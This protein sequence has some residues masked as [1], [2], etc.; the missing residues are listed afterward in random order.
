MHFTA[1]SQRCTTLCVWRRTRLK[2]CLSCE[3]LSAACT[4]YSISQAQMYYKSN[5]LR[6]AYTNNWNNWWV[7][8]LYWLTT[9]TVRTF[10]SMW[11]WSITILC[12]SS[13]T[14]FSFFSISSASPQVAILVRVA[15]LMAQKTCSDWHTCLFRVWC[16]QI[17]HVGVSGPKNRQIMTRK[18]LDL[19]NF[20]QNIALTLEPPRVN[21]PWTSK[22]VAIC[23][24]FD[25]SLPN[26]V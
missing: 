17:Y 16:L 25:Q 8:K 23:L 11:W 20:L 18:S 9:E 1:Y 14:F 2:Y 10:C 5:Q 3:F 15:S 24:L 4:R 6:S 26:L 12:L 7:L 22:T 21:Y 13:P 19:T